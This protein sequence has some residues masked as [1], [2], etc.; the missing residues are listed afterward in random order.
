[1]RVPFASAVVLSAVAF[2]RCLAGLP[3]MPSIPRQ[4]DIIEAGWLSKVPPYPVV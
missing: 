4:D 1:M 3:P 2:H